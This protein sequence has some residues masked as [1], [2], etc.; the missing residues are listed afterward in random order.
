MALATDRLYLFGQAYI[1]HLADGVGVYTDNELRRRA[2]GFVTS[3][4]KG[5][6][7]PARAV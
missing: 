6:F 4:S 2:T 7:R 5:T 3:V 1:F